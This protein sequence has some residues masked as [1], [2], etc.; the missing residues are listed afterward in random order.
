[1]DD[2]HRPNKRSRARA[3]LPIGSLPDHLYPKQFTL[4]DKDRPFTLFLR[5][6]EALTRA[7]DWSSATACR[8]LP[9]W[10]GGDARVRYNSLPDVIKNGD[11]YKCLVKCLTELYTPPA[12][13]G[14]ALQ[15]FNTI[16]REK[17][18]T[19]EAYS[20]RLNI[21]LRQAEPNLS[22]TSREKFVINR[23]ISDAS[24]DIQ[25]AFATGPARPQ[26][27]KEFVESASAIEETAKRADAKLPNGT[28]AT[29][30]TNNITTC[31]QPNSE[32][33]IS[34]DSEE[35][36]LSDDDESPAFRIPTNGCLGCGN[37]GHKWK[38]C[39][40]SKRPSWLDG[41]VLRVLLRIARG[42]SVE[43]RN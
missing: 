18:E 17:D 24:R 9:V 12:Q 35:R 41:W 28:L 33:C 2:L 32:D 22:S 15:R 43:T 40:V 37:D 20:D 11:S 25:L 27:L 39:T 6:F 30:S 36:T 23:I 5:D 19:L 26:T 7:H 21:P 1:M 3:E 14:F 13:A 10:L 31:T 29:V 4:S 42:E 16:A 8:W 34:S 38:Q